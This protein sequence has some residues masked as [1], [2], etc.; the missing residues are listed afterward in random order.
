MVYTKN[1]SIA[2]LTDFYELTMAQ[3]YWKIDKADE[4][5]VF[6]LH[7]RKPPFEGTYVVTAG[8]E[9]VLAL[10]EDFHFTKEDID[11]L[12]RQKTRGGSPFFEEAFL[13]YL[14]E[15]RIVCDIDAI[16]EGRV[17]FPQEPLLRVQGPLLQVQLL[18]TLLL[19]IINFQSLIATKASRV[20]WAAGSDPVIEFGLR[21]AQGLDGGLSASRASFIGGST[22]TSNVLAGKVYGIPVFG[23][24]SHSWVMAFD[25]EQE[26]F[27]S[28]GKTSPG[29]CAFLLDTYDTLQGV[30]HA[31]QVAKK[32]QKEGI[33]IQSVRLDSGDLADLSQKVRAILD[34]EGFN[35]VKILAS[36]ELDEKIIRDLKLQGSAIDIWC[37]GTSLATGKDQGALDGVY[38]LS[39][40][41]KKKE[42]WNYRMKLSDQTAKVSTPGILQ[43]RRFYEEGKAIG[44]MLWD[45]LSPMGSVLQA[46]DSKDPMLHHFF[47]KQLAYED[48]LIPVMKK[49]KRVYQTP[50]LQEIQNKTNQ[51]LSR[52]PDP[53]RR[54]MNPHPFFVGLEKSL[55]DRKMNLI[56][57]FR[58]H[59]AL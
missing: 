31:A 1:F 55:F 49:G 27:Y 7:Y 30:K 32:L 19:N 21:R 52:F 29:N 20:V 17:V 44:D 56:H 25:S 14:Y 50:P 26:A 22:A 3:G 45:T 24:Q 54:L 38:K 2:L 16:E 51:E 6:H 57:Q 18:E 4:E 9:E 47:D 10:V 53:M 23:T 11:F 5:A 58:S 8:L 39:A 36:N 42:S 35:H 59:S 41:R 15:M 40:L 13:K 34:K 12:R 37:V 33:A 48:L 46:I 28:F 43:V